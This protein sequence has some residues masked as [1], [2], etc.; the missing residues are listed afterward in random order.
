[1]SDTADTAELTTQAQDQAV[2]QAEAGAQAEAAAQAVAQVSPFQRPDVDRKFLGLVVHGTGDQPVG[3]MLR[4]VASEF[5]P[6]IRKRFDPKAGIAAKPLDEGDPAEV[7]I[8]FRDRTKD[9]VYELRF[10]EV[11]WSHAFE[12]ISLGGFI[13]GLWGF[14][15]AWCRKRHTRPWGTWRCL[16]W[17]LY[18]L[19]QRIIADVAIAVLVAFLL[20]LVLL[21]TLT[22]VVGLQRVLPRWFASTN[23]G[24]VRFVTYGQTIIVE[25]IIIVLS[26]V[27]ILLLLLLWLVESVSPKPLLPRWLVGAHRSLVNMVTRQLGDM[28]AYMRQPWEASQIRVRFEERFHQVVELLNRDPDTKKVEA[29]FVIAYSMGSVVAYEALTGRRMTKLIQETFPAQQQPTFHFISVGSALNSAWDFVPKSEYLRFY[30]QFAPNVYWLN[31]WSEC[32]PVARGELR[33]PYPNNIP[34]LPVVNQMDLFSDHFAYWNNA[35]QVVAPILDT[36]TCSRLSPA[37]QMNTK[38]RRRRVSVL[39]A[40]KAL[41]WLVFPAVYFSLLFTGGGQWISGWAEQTFLDDEGW[42]RYVLSPALWA[43]GAAAVAVGV[44]STVV[45]WAWDLWDRKV[46][47]R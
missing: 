21:T 18:V 9:E 30:R 25:L 43:A 19:L 14:L 38:A 44:Y 28:W 41:A 33:P 42:R 32:D 11:W 6:L 39:V 34:D 45:K 29:V 10:V 7:R 4:H 2:A 24:L 12:A 26:P 17:F 37:L 22:E 1:M 23:G 3:S 31:L 8:W 13:A 15:L 27:L 16:G 35:E 47:Y 5:L 40:L 20:P 46:K 36:I